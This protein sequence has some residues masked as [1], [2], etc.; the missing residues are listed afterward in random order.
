MT[1]PHHYFATP[2]HLR[3]VICWST[4]PCMC[5]LTADWKTFFPPAPPFIKELLLG[6]GFGF[7]RVTSVSPWKSSVPWAFGSHCKYLSSLFCL[8]VNLTFSHSSG[9]FQVFVLNK[10]VRM[11]FVISPFLSSITFGRKKGLFWLEAAKYR[12]KNLELS[13]CCNFISHLNHKVGYIYTPEA[14]S[15]TLSHVLFR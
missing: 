5:I 7:C 3:L 15:R 9:H 11:W 8:Q 1:S 13:R 2:S 14:P 4:D 6:W 12:K 10:R